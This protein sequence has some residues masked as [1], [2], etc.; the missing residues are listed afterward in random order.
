MLKFLRDDWIRIFEETKYVIILDN[1]PSTI[2]Y[3]G[4]IIIGD[5][6]LISNNVPTIF[7]YIIV[8]KRESSPKKLIQ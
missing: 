5:I 4:R 7:Y 3:D 6:L 2:I 8:M 1:S